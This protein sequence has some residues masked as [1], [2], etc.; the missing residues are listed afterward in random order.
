MK[1]IVLW[2]NGQEDPP[3]RVLLYRDGTTKFLRAEFKG[4]DGQWR[5]AE[6]TPTND[7]SSF[8]V[9]EEAFLHHHEELLR[10]R[11]EEMAPMFQ[12]FEA[13]ESYSENQLVVTA[14]RTIIFRG[15][16]LARRVGVGLEIIAEGPQRDGALEVE[17]LW[18]RYPQASVL[19]PNDFTR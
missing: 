12:A 17:A 3:M 2:D 9:L 16:L 7:P 19:N 6:P 8:E 10:L 14:G 11:M 13:M 15:L 4:V 5:P 18:R 1:S